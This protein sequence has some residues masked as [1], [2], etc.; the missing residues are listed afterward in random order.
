MTIIDT[1]GT[2][3]FSSD[4]VSD[5]DDFG[6]DTRDVTYK[7]IALHNSNATIGTDIFIVFNFFQLDRTEL[8]ELNTIFTTNKA[9]NS[10]ITSIT[11]IDE[12][13]TGEKYTEM[14]GATNGIYIETKKWKQKKSIQSKDIK[15]WNTR[16]TFRVDAVT[17]KTK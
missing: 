7:N 3:V 10:S 9:N 4:L 12:V 2:H 14:L 15:F 16:L 13:L 6:T 1:S 11:N 8:T 17:F 5:I